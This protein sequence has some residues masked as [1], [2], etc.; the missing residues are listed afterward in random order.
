MSQPCHPCGICFTEHASGAEALA[1][2]GGSV[3][4]EVPQ[5][6]RCYACGS[7]NLA[8]NRKGERC[9]KTCGREQPQVVSA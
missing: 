9:C 1:C 7:T 6:V 5:V 4:T 3:S 2:C 8:L